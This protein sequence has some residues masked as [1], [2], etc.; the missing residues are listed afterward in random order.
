MKEVT[1]I[2]KKLE[3]ERKKKQAELDILEKKQMRK[4]NRS[5]A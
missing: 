4:K 2:K 1:K 3:R 5:K